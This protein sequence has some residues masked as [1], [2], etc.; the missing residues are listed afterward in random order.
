MLSRSTGIAPLIRPCVGYILFLAGRPGNVI[1]TF[2]SNAT[3]LP[4]ITL[5]LILGEGG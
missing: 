3:V 1:A 5:E 2:V 4:V